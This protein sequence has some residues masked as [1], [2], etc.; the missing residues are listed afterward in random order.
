MDAIEI[1]LGH[2]SG[3]RA[4]TAPCSGCGR[5]VDHA[6]A[7]RRYQPVLCVYCDMIDEA[8]GREPVAGALDG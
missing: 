2:R 4:T 3:Y 6:G 8:D 1:M 7:R 5:K